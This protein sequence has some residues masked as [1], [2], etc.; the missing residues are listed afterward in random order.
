[1]YHK[2]LHMMLYLHLSDDD[3]A[4]ALSE[5]CRVWYYFASLA[6][7]YPVYALLY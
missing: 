2:R 4:T 3:L 5:I 7:F 6:M 1:M